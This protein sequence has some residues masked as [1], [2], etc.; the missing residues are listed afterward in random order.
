M[1]LT[2]ID[3]SHPG[4]AHVDSFWAASAGEEVSGTPPLSG[5][6]E[7]DIAIIG[8]G[9]TGLSTAYH[10]A[11]E[12][13]I[14]ALVLDANRVGWGCSGRNGGFCSTGMGK[15]GPRAWAERWGLDEARRIFG[16]SRDAVA[17][18][19][20]ILDRERI[21]ADRTPTG[22]LELAH[23]ADALPEMKQRSQWLR[24]NLGL[25]ARI[26]GKDELDREYLTSQEA[27]GALHMDEGF[28]IHPMKYTRGLAR[29]ALANG[30]TIHAGSPVIGWTKEGNRHLLRTPTGTVRARTV[31]VATNG[32][33]NDSLHPQLT[34]RLLPALSN[35]IVTRPLTEA[36]RASV[37]WR[38]HLK[39]WDSR[40]LL[41]YYRLLPDNRIMFGSRGGI[42]DTPASNAERR[43]WMKQRIG[44]MFPPL[45]HV[46]DEY[47]WYGWVSVAYDKNPH[48][49][50]LP[51]DPTVH[52]ALAYIGAGVALAS[53]AGKLLAQRIATGSAEYG[54]LLNV[55]LPKFPFPPLRRTWQR[56]AYAWYARQDERGR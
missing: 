45:A 39:I 3:L 18:V 9:Y 1:S 8:A 25:N 24:E 49:G 56:I 52:Y 17:T 7:T 34:G 51:G 23:R 22:T 54:K 55:P 36:E 29:A 50:T 15:D 13:G 43:R 32:Y 53:H 27:F 10:L 35:I 26:V 21:D 38:T 20:G 40:I 31:V 28:G 46:E 33:T 19:A 4:A 16:I 11:R 41:F 48:F 44:E 14:K 37:N 12:H 42:E 2:P 30:V 6:V 47:F 5:D